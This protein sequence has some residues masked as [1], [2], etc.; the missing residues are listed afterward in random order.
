MYVTLSLFIQLIALAFFLTSPALAA[1]NPWDMKLP[2]KKATIKYTVSGSAN[3]TETLYVSD[4]GKNRARYHKA[5]QKIMF[6]TT[7]TDEIEITTPD[8]IYTI[9]MTE[10]SGT[11]VINP[12]KFMIEEYDKLSGSE[13]KL[14]NKNVEEM[15]RS[16]L[17]SM[18]GQIEQNVE[19]ILGFK[20]DR[21]SVSG[22]TVYT[23]HGTDIALKTETSM[24]GMSFATVATDIDKGS[25]DKN[26][27]EPP[28][29]ISVVHD[30]QADDA[31]RAMAKNTI[32]MLKSPDAA[33][34]M[35]NQGADMQQQNLENR[36][37]AENDKSQADQ[38]EAGMGQD[39]NN[40]MDALK[41]LW[42]K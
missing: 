41:G 9:D 1:K 21:S 33:Q 22:S 3:G 10:N 5:S 31:A 25:V 35:Q 8:W 20:C 11:K 15:G 19:K 27:F 30:Q 37:P 4:Y 32:D 18:G 28:A 6:I 39:I 13:K 42:G 16:A 24:M 14:V 40:A 2:F 23:I 34:N 38:N 7:N 17:S 29:G 12:Q 36:P 26:V